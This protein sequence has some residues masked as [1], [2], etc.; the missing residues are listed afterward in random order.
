MEVFDFVD[1]ARL[2]DDELRVRGFGLFGNLRRS[3][4]RVGG[5]CGCAAERGGEEREDELGAVREEDHHD[6][7][8]VNAEF[9]KTG[10]DATGGDMDVGVSVHVAGGTVDQARL[11]GELGDVLEDV[12]VERE[13]I[14]DVNIRKL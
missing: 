10:G 1:V 2:G 5:G 13:V 3:E 9:L 11:G 4:K 6:V 14:G 7:V 12:V 8:F